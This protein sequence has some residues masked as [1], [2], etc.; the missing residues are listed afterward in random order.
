VELCRNALFKIFSKEAIPINLEQFIS[1]FNGL[2][3]QAY[4]YVYVCT[5]TE[6]LLTVSAD[7]PKSQRSYA[8]GKLVHFRIDI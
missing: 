6:G 8:V 1:I 7:S 5:I 2:K 3:N 4:I